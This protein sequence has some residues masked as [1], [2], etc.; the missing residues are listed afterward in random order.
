MFEEDAGITDDADGTGG[1][2]GTDGIDGMTGAEG[3]GVEDG[4]VVGRGEDRLGEGD[5]E[6]EKDEEDEDRLGV[7]RADEIDEDSKG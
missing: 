5:E 1:K 4:E 3:V 2:G 7:G 6:D